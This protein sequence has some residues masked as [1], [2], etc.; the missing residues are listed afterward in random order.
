MLLLELACPTPVRPLYPTTARGEEASQ[1]S[2]KSRLP[3]R[4]LSACLRLPGDPKPAALDKWELRCPWPVP[5][6]CRSSAV[7]SHPESLRPVAI[8]QPGQS[9]PQQNRL[10]G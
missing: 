8:P 9:R 7:A 3:L 6:Q 10:S 5:T 2:H 4:P 1:E